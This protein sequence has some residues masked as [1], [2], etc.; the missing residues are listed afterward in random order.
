MPDGLIV[1]LSRV[2]IQRVDDPVFDIMA[3][4]SADEQAGMALDRED[5]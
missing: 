1:F 5:P 2:K 4:G 3:G